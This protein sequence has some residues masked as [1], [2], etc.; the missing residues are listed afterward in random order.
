MNRVRYCCQLLIIVACSQALA[1]EC[2]RV[3][4]SAHPNYPPYHWA[5][6]DQIVG[7]S[8][9]VAKI[10]LDELGMPYE[11]RFVGPWKRVLLNAEKGEIDLVLALKDVPDRRQYLEFTRSPFYEN[12]VAVFVPKGHEFEF[13]QWSDLKGRHGTL[14]LGD[15]HGEDFD[16]YVENELDVLRVAGLEG[17]FN[18]LVNERSSY[19]I[20][21]LYTGRAYLETSGLKSKVSILPNPVSTGVIHFAFSGKSPCLS[22]M[23]YFDKRLEELRLSGETGQL[24]EQNIER[25]RLYFSPPLLQEE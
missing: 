11:S 1:A 24:L 25:W 2:K 17:N 3:V 5:E 14:N 8:V 6:G 20:T 16:L 18:A 9:D 13:K 23:S 10:I 19:F 12:P 22:L 15:R 7:A 4:F 21:G